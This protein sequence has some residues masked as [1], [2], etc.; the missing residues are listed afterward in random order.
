MITPPL[1]QPGDTV[2]IL[3]PASSIAPELIDGAVNRLIEAGLN[4][5]VMPHAK[6]VSGTYSGSVDER[7]SDFRQA[8]ANP[9]VKAIL[10]S[11]G[12]YGAVHLLDKLTPRPIWL[13]GF[14]D[15]S[16]IHGLWSSAGI[17]SVHGSMAKHL[18]NFPLT[19]AATQSLLNIICRGQFP[20]YQWPSTPLNRPGHAEGT[21]VGG[22]LA[23]I[24][25]L[26]STPYFSIPQ[27]SIL[28]I[29]DIAEPIYKVQ[30]ILY[31]LRLSGTFDRIGALVV[32]QFTEY[33]S[34]RNYPDMETM[35]AEAV[36]GYDFPMAFN[37]PFG[38]VDANLPFVMGATTR[39]EVSLD[40]VFFS[41]S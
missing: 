32:G 10:C 11:R 14:S 22:N 29:E 30:R 15:I 5:V 24:D 20:E 4:V 40:K 31:Q 2:A 16:A 39:L 17:Q 9:E 27:G 6:G 21:A 8:L 28:I 26:I 35:I 37:A 18:T 19:D 33:K 25:G 7:L 41:Q 36:A 1:L 38:H 12:G 13:I 34:D 3:S 23:V